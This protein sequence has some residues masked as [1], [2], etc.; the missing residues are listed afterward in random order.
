MPTATKMAATGVLPFVRGVDLSRNDFSECHFPKHVQDMASLRWLRLN[1]TGIDKLPEELADLKKL[2]HIHVAHNKLVSLHGA[3]LAALPNLRAVNARYNQLRNTGIPGEIFENEELSV[4]DFSHNELKM[5]PSEL[6]N[7][8][9]L[10]VLNLSNNR[11]DNISN[12]L[13]INL[14]DL[15]F[16][17]LSN[18]KL[19]SLPPQ[20]RRLV[21]LQTLILNNNPLLHAQLRQLPS[22]TALQTLHLRNTQRTSSNIP[23]ALETLVNLTD[24]DLAYNELSRVPEA[25]YTL[26]SLKRLNLSNNCISELSLLIDTWTNV[27]VLNV[28]CNKLKSLPGSLSKLVSL[29]RLYINVN[30]LD[31]EGI[32]ASIG[33]LQNLE[34]FVA[35]NNNLELIPEGLCRCGKLKRLILNRNR[36]VTLPDAIHALT[37]LETLDIRDNPNLVMPPKPK[38]KKTGSGPEFYNIDFSLQHQL[39]LATGAPP[40]PS[41]GQQPS[42]DPLARKMRLR[43]VKDTAGDSDKVLKGMTGVTEEKNKRLKEWTKDQE[44]EGD[45]QEAKPRRW[46]EGL[47][48]PQ[49]DYSDFF[50]EDTGQTAGVTVWQI[51]NFLPVLIEEAQ[52]GKFYDADCYIILKTSLDDQGNTEWMIFYWIGADAT[53][54]KKACAAIHSVNLRNL[55]GAECRTIREEQA[56]ESEEFLEVFD[57]NIS[58]IEGGTAS[59]FFTVE[60]TQYTVRMYRVSIPKTY[61]IHLEPVPVKQETRGLLNMVKFCCTLIDI[62]SSRLMAEKINKNERKNEAEISVIRQGQETKAFW[63]LLGGLP[64]EIMP[65]VP[66][67]F[68]PPKPRLYQVCLGMGYLE[69]PQ[70]ELG[71]GQRLRKVV[72]NTRNVY[73][74]DCYSDVFVWLGRKSTRLVR[75]AALKLS[76]ELCNMLPRPDVAMVTRVQEGTETQVFKSKF[77]GWDDIVPVDY[78]KSAEEAHK[79]GPEI[80]RDEEQAKKEAKTDLSALFMPRQPPM[81][82]AEAEQLMEEWNEDLDGMESFVLEGKK[83]VRLPEEEIGHFYSGDSYVFLCR[84]CHFYS[85]D[86]YVFLCQYCHFYS[87][88][89]YVF[90]CQYCHFFS[91]DSYVWQGRDASNMGWLTFTFSLQKKFE[92][93]FPGKLEV[94][95]THQQQENLKFLA[96]FKKKFII[97]QGHRKDKPAEPQP[98]LFQIRANGSPLCTRCI[99]IPAEGKLLNSEFCYIL[100][101]PFDNDETNGI[102]YVWIGRCSEP[103]EAKLVEDV[104]NDIN[105][106]GSY[107]VQILNEGE[108][109]ENFFWVALG[110]RTEYEE[111]AEFMRHTRLFRCSNEKGFFTVSE[112]CSDFCQDDLADDDVM[113]LDT[114]AEVFVWVGP[115]ASQIEAKLAIKSAQVYIQHLRSKGIQRKLRLTVKNKEPYKFTCCFHGWGRHRQQAKQFKGLGWVF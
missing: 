5:T 89:S 96:H 113:L 11:I 87:G 6:E 55:L 27:E 74:L 93:L 82:S 104:S 39:R 70:V 99:Q 76:Q 40:S 29:K 22:M 34:H 38:E 101:V 35:S 91:G 88:D 24:V 77:T 47:E 73:I 71:S 78:T 12:Q 42:K 94:V 17:D 3:E 65:H 79:G 19:E 86:S 32:P 103:D 66:D 95:R 106:N 90:L 62:S 54:D 2:E 112:K 100:K 92:S 109:P 68:A 85:G 46:D 50:T 59:G 8:K 111:D 63:E 18:N 107:S 53:L 97:H 80:K 51:E 84:Y 26:S 98:S 10:L 36:L 108:E 25:L 9:G 1:K 75:A 4:L 41:Q 72:L 44:Q 31:F 105:P 81:S 67:D 23:T 28:S 21:H 58:Y 102:V 57:H 37:D 110:G 114:G 115:T 7:A 69:L 52:H 60:D 61:N 16:L 13:F 45:R 30:Q 49:L 14:T 64:D 20:M 56:D 48:R 43:K 15:L 33:K 83:F